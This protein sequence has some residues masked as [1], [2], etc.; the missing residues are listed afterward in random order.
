MYIMVEYEKLIE[1]NATTDFMLP[2]IGEQSHEEEDGI[3]DG[4]ESINLHRIVQTYYDIEGFDN[5]IEFINNE[6]NNI[7][8]KLGKPMESLTDAYL[9]QYFL[10]KY[11]MNLYKH[12]LE[13]QSVEP[14]NYDLDDEETQAMF[15]SKINSELENNNATSYEELIRIMYPVYDA[16][17]KRKNGISGG[18]RRTRTRTRTRT[19]RRR[20]TRHRRSRSATYLRPRRYTK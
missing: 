20:S 19:R 2:G 14:K 17:N 1:D 6:K 12:L 5:I 3:G 7:V 8:Q 18:R 11:L 16:L 4:D 15:A 9:S 10:F 13:I